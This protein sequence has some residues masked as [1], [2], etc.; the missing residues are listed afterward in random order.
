MVRARFITF[1]GGEGSGKSTQARLLVAALQG[2]GHDVV[3]TRE[4]GGAPGAEAIRDLLL[5]GPLERWDAL[6]EA[7][8]HSAAR[9]DH[10]LRTIRPAL[11]RGAW[12][13]C[14]RFADSTT[15]Y[16]G[17]GLGL[18][19]D[20]VD[21]LTDLVAEGLRPDLTLI[22]DIAVETGLARAGSRGQAATR[23]E[24]MDEAFHHRL[25]AAFLDIARHEPKRCVVID[26]A[27][28]PETV[29]A[30]VL[31]AVHERLAGAGAG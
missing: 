7:L 14:D 16:Q 21:R 8:L 15:A 13:V 25:R 3:A 20:T 30:A 5:D 26:A 23:Y 11:A 24:R 18:G 22:L 17:F 10:L 19:R 29:A 4:P 27:A 28:P 12:V 2:E 6:S 9:R 31:A 1:E